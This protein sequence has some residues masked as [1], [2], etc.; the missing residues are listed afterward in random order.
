MCAFGEAGIPVPE[1]ISVVGSDDQP[2]SRYFTPP[3]TAVRQD[4]EELGRGC[5]DVMLSAIKDGKRPRA[6][7]SD[8][9]KVSHFAGLASSGRCN[10]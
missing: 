2:E 3:L 4:F 1:D 9:R 5:M 6:A 8:G 10:T 7:V